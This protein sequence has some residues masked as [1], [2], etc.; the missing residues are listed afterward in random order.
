[1]LCYICDITAMNYISKYLCE[2]LDI[3]FACVILFLEPL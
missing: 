2:S 3:T 1:M